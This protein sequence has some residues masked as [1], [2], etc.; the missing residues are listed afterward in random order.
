MSSRK[1]IPGFL[2]SGPTDENTMITDY[3]L[4]YMAARESRCPDEETRNLQ[5]SGSELSARVNSLLLGQQ[6]SLHRELDRISQ[7]VSKTSAPAK[8]WEMEM[9]PPMPSVAGN[10]DLAEA[11][12]PRFWLKDM[13]LNLLPFGRP[14]RLT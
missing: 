7:D 6:E 13:I 1:D 5:G 4:E 9:G 3:W 12:H 14:R 11:A 2:D 10:T 8:P